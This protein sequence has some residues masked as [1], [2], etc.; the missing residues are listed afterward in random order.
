MNL[1]NVSLVPK[2]Y[3]EKDPRPLTYL[4][5]TTINIVSYTKSVNTFN[6]YQLLDLAEDLAKRQGFILLPW[7]C[8]HWNRAK[9]Y[10]KD[11]KVKVGRKTF[12]MMKPGELTKLEEQKLLDYI[13]GVSNV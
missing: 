7:S 13:D 5:P 11:R 8:I 12:F 6:Y 4:N 1:E 10:S 2:N 3:K 9:L